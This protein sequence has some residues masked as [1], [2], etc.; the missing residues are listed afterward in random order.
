LR[1][2]FKKYRWMKDSKRSESAPPDRP[3]KKDD[4]LLDALRYV[5]ML[6]PLV[7]DER[8]PYE[9]ETAKHRM[10]RQHLKR[11]RGIRSSVDPGSGFGPGQFA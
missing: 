5:L 2:E 1:S 6:R 10:L 7:P 9:G 4:H 8:R 11:L 3:V